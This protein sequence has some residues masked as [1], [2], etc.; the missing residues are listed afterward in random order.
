MR[1]A[2]QH[3]TWRCVAEQI[4]NV[5]DSVLEPATGYAMHSFAAASGEVSLRS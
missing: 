4:A 1:R 5:Y 3:Y 2:Y